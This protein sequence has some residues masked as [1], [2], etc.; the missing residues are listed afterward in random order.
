MQERVHNSVAPFAARY[1]RWMRA[2]AR[3]RRRRSLR[4]ALK[5]TVAT[6][7]VGIFVATTWMFAGHFLCCSGQ[8][9]AARNQAYEL[10]KC[11]AIFKTKH[12]RWPAHL[13]ELTPIIEQ[14][15]RDPWGRAYILLVPGWRNVDRFDVVSAGLDGVF[16]TA[17]DV[18][19]W[20]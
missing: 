20:P 7:I 1:D 5:I 3:R 16:F 18:G 14:V 9:D 12:A 2:A 8:T 15:P 10:V 17:D 6:T 4:R 13:D 19:N 11:A